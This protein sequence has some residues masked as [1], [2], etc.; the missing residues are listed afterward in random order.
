[1]PRPKKEKTNIEE[2]S[3]E[4]KVEIEKVLGEAHDGEDMKCLM[5]DGTIKFIPKDEV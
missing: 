1:M 5:K 2:T 3:S 4:V